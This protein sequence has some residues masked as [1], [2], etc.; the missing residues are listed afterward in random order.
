MIP[1]L[2]GEQWKK[3]DPNF[4]SLT[5]WK[6]HSQSGNQHDLSPW[7]RNAGQHS[8]KD[9]WTWEHPMFPH[10]NICCPIW[11]SLFICGLYSLCSMCIY[12]GIFV[13]AHNSLPKRNS[14]LASWSL[15]C[16]L[17]FEIVSFVQNNTEDNPELVLYV[18]HGW[19]T[20]NYINS[21]PAEITTIT[22]Y[23]WPCC[24]WHPDEEGD[25]SADWGRG[26]HC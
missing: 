6:T 5:S 4:C 15:L 7:T 18:D 25:S 23:F 20:G 1:T 14:F 26:H 12:V 13:C 11:G 9:D 24:L 19:K 21:R 10:G 22:P 17:L 16:F 2:S 3:K 8:G